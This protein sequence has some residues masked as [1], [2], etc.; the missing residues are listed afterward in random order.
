MTCSK[1]AP[2]KN[3][4]LESDV[5]MQ[6]KMSRQVVI[7]ANYVVLQ[8]F[9][10]LCEEDNRWRS[11]VRGFRPYSQHHVLRAVIVRRT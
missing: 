9:D 11:T 4:L 6:Q 2:G 5:D 3:N 7:V 10:S 1:S 8:W